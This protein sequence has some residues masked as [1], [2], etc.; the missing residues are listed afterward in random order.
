MSG[1]WAVAELTSHA[2]ARTGM[3]FDNAS[4]WLCRFERGEIVEA[5]AYV[6]SALVQRLL[7]EEARA[8]SETE[9]E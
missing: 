7:D 4:C 6:D 9:I 1:D 5:R 3:A 8:H 2:T